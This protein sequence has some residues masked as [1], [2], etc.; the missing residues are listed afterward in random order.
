MIEK[1]ELRF[2][3]DQI[4]TNSEVIVESIEI[5]FFPLQTSRVANELLGNNLKKRAWGNGYQSSVF[6]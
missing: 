6:Q 1:H 3:A 4:V 5:D 2:G